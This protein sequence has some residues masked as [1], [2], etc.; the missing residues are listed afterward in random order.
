MLPDADHIGDAGHFELAPDAGGAERQAEMEARRLHRR[1]A[2]Q[3]RIAA[4]VHGGDLHHRARPF[5]GRIVAGEFAERSFRQRLLLWRQQHAFENDLR[6]RREREPCRRPGNHLDR[7]IFDGAS[8]IV[9]RPARRQIFETC[10]EQRR[11]RAIY[12]RERARL[13][14]VP[15][16]LGNDGAVAALVVE[17][18]RDFVARVHLHAIDR[19]V[20]PAAVR[21]AHDHDRARADESAAVVA[22][23]D[24]R[25]KLGEVDVL[26]AE[27]VLQ[28]SGLL[29]RNGR[30]RLE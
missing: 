8:E 24:G 4:V 30:A 10:D 5:G 9:F 27:R 18:H 25:R 19:R 2:K 21:I 3:D 12:H 13:A 15:I 1:R 17:L 7:R 16:F 28:K 14:G 23:P 11:V 20:D 6:L 22:V 26:A 29:D